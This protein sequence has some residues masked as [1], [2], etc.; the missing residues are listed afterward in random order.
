MFKKTVKFALIC[1]LLIGSY[2]M[3]VRDGNSEQKQLTSSADYETYGEDTNPELIDVEKNILLPDVT[4][5]EKTHEDVILGEDPVVL[6]VR[7][8]LQTIDALEKETIER[9]PMTFDA[10][11]EEVKKGRMFA[12]DTLTILTIHMLAEKRTDKFGFPNQELMKISPLIK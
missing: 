7:D 12:E 10:L 5:Q 8:A 3:G 1:A 4:V 11:F 2:K 9:F 6:Y